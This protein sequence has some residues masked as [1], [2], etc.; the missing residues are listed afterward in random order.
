MKLFNIKI[1]C[2]L[3]LKEISVN[4]SKSVENALNRMKSEGFE[5]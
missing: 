5:T 2:I 1:N 3:E 4:F